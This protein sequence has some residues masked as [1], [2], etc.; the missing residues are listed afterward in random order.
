MH[1]QSIGSYRIYATREAATTETSTTE[2]TLV[3]LGIAVKKN[4]IVRV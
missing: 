1:T 2:A 4:K 3:M